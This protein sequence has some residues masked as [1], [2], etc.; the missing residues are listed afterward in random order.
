MSHSI[1]HCSHEVGGISGSKALHTGPRQG[2]ATAMRLQAIRHRLR[3]DA[4]WRG[5]AIHAYPAVRA[6]LP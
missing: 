2:R 1:E 5:T 6:L 3:R 4:Q